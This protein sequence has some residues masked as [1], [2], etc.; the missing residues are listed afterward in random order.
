MYP[1]HRRLLLSAFAALI[2]ATGFQVSLAAKPPEFLICQLDNGS[3]ISI[4]I[5]N[6]DGMRGAVHQCL[7]FWHGHPHGVSR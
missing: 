6:F 5:D 2:L 4:V 3:E 7:E 1:V